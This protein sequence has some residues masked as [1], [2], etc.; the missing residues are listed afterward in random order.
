MNPNE[1]IEMH[2]IVIIL[3]AIFVTV[4]TAPLWSEWLLGI[5]KKL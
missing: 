4:I 5:D 3:Y 1:R 2:Y